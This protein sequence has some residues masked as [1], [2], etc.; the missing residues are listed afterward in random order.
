MGRGR[1]GQSREAI[2]RDRERRLRAKARCNFIVSSES[3]A[4][5]YLVSAGRAGRGCSLKVNMRNFQASPSRT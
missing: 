4:A 2:I 1:H 3:K 5:R